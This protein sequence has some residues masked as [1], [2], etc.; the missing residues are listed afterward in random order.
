MRKTL[1]TFFVLLCLMGASGVQVFAQQANNSD[2]DNLTVRQKAYVLGSFF[3]STIAP[4]GSTALTLGSSSATSITLTTDAGSVVFDGELDGVAPAGIN[5]DPT[6]GTWTFTKDAAGAVVLTA[7]DDDTTAALT[8]RPGGAAAM[9][10]GGVSMTALTVTTDSTGTAEVAL[11]AGSIDSTEILNSTILPADQAYPGRGRFTVCGDATTVN[12]GTV[13]YGPS[14]VLVSSATVGLARKCDT[15]AAGNATEGN[16]DEL[17]FTAKAFQ[18]LS[19][20]CL[21]PDANAA[22]TFTARSAAAA[23]TPSV[24]CSDAD[25]DLGCTA[26]IQTTNAIASGATFA[27][28]VSSAGDIG[29]VPFVCTVDVAF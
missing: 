21:H 15:T 2:V 20:D 14:M 28:A 3:A 4:L 8:V 12:N 18:I 25:N 1:K 27:V 23:T 7:A 26:N 24:T 22:L 6:A 11:P 19:M 17:A 10:V 29:T 5:A 13:Y 9:T 16:A